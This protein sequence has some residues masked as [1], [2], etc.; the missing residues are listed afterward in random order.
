MG[1]VSDLMCFDVFQSILGG[2]GGLR[3]GDFLGFQGFHYYNFS[4]SSENPENLLLQ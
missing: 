4:Y 3:G 2:M 1:Y